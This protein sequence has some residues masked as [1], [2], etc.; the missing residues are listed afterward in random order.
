MEG[1][2]HERGTMTPRLAFARRFVF[3]V[4]T[5]LVTQ[6]DQCGRSEDSDVY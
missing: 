2:G 6:C 1:A 5:V 4:L 3:T